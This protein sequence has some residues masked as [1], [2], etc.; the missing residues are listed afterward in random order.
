[1]PMPALVQRLLRVMPV[2][3]FVRP[4][5]GL[6]WGRCD[7]FSSFRQALEPESSLPSVQTSFGE[8]R[9]ATASCIRASSAARLE[10]QCRAGQDARERPCLSP[11]PSLLNQVLLSPR[12]NSQGELESVAVFG[13]FR[14]LGG[15]CLF[16][17]Y[18]PYVPFYGL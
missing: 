11:M 6:L 13:W 8:S 3:S 10:S 17:V 5:A 15:L 18:L 12:G 7:I 9:G 2:R 4:E 14:L 16:H 1:M